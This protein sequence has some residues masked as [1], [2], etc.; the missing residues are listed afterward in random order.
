MQSMPLCYQ[1]PWNEHMSNTRICRKPAGIISH[2]YLGWFFIFLQYIFSRDYVFEEKMSKI[3]YAWQTC[4]TRQNWQPFHFNFQNQVI[5]N[6]IFLS[7]FALRSYGTLC[8]MIIVAIICLF[9]FW[10]FSWV[11]WAVLVCID[12]IVAI[13]SVGTLWR[14]NNLKQ[15]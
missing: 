6:L 5:F 12:D 7:N 8:H 1:V 4:H 9:V 15:K 3:M 14:W 2:K 13:Q 11:T 10:V